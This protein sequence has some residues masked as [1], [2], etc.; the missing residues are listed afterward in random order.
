MIGPGGIDSSSSSTRNP[1]ETAPHPP[2]VEDSDEEI[3]R[4]FGKDDEDNNDTP[5]ASKEPHG[6]NRREKIAAYL[7]DQQEK[8]M[9]PKL[10]IEKQHL[11]LFKEDLALKRKIMETSGNVDQQFLDNTSKM[12][13]TMEGV[14]NAI[15]GCLDLM[16]R[17][18]QTQQ[19]P[20]MPYSVHRPSTMPTYSE[21]PYG[22]N[23]YFPSNC[24]N[25]NMHQP[26]APGTES[27]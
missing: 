11:S 23:Q 24:F 6:S 9:T 14:G 12:A 17:M 15:T 1:A 27:D 2:L 7:K 22:L 25:N 10:N 3:E 19:Q 18:Y 20:P 5:S 8:K 13:K 26:D 4:L 21:M 16:T